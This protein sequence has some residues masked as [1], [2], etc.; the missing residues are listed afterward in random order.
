MAA[1]LLES[2][3]RSVTLIELSRSPKAVAHYVNRHLQRSWREAFSRQ[4]R[5]QFGRQLVG[6]DFDRQVVVDQ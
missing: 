2:F 1:Q 5:N 3:D 6:A 4:N